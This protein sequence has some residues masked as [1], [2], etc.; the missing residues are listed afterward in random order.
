MTTGQSDIDVKLNLEKFLTYGILSRL[1]GSTS[2][3]AQSF[4]SKILFLKLKSAMDNST[5]FFRN[6]VLVPTTNYLSPC[7]YWCCCWPM[8]WPRRLIVVAVL[9]YS[10]V[11]KHRPAATSFFYISGSRAHF[12]QKTNDIKLLSADVSWSQVSNLTAKNT[13]NFFSL[14]NGRKLTH[15]GRFMKEFKKFA[16]KS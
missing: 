12:P 4:T 14:K 10:A 5:I 16:S 9:R 7:S 6:L 8:C 1:L 13:T 2:I 3:N 11:H 15:P